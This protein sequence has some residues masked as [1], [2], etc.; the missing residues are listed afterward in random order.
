MKISLRKGVVIPDEV[1]NSYAF[2]YLRK[3][4][5]YELRQIDTLTSLMNDDHADFD[6]LYKA[7]EIYSISVDSDSELDDY[8]KRVRMNLKNRLESDREELING[9]KEKLRQ[10][11]RYTE[12]SITLTREKLVVQEQVSGYCESLLDGLEQKKEKQKEKKQ[13]LNK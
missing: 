1:S 2:E 11:Q 12:Q 4:I 3:L 7:N 5:N 13:L 10:L 9:L 8:A 6:Y